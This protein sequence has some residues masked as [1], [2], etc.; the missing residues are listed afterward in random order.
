MIKTHPRRLEPEDVCE[1]EW[2]EWYRLTAGERWMASGQLWTTYLTLGGT[3]DP[4]PDT[5]SPFHD[6]LARGSVSAHGR[7]SMHRLRR[8]GV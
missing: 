2:A 1:P 5:Q 8:R 4:E 6:A 7:S 3:L